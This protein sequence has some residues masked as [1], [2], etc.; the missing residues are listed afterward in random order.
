ML[1][2]FMM[3][4]LFIS[5]LLQSLLAKVFG[6]SSTLD[7]YTVGNSISFLFINWIA[8]GA[9][10]YVLVPVFTEYR[11]DGK[12]RIM[13]AANSFIAFLIFFS[14]FIT[15]VF[16]VIAPQIVSIL[17]RGFDTPTLTLAVN[18]AR[19][20]MPVF[21]I[22]V[23]CGI[24][25]GLLRAYE[26]YNITAIARCFE[27][28][29]IIG[30]I[31]VFGKTLG[32]YA[33]PVGMLSGALLSLAVH[34]HY[35]PRTG[36]RFRFKLIVREEKVRVMVSTF[37]LFGLISMSKHLVFLVDRLVASFLAP[38]SIA[39][40]HFASRFQILIVMIVPMAVS[41]P[42]F[43]RLNQHLYAQDKEKVISTIHHGL[44]LIAVMVFPLF[45]LFVLVRVPLIELWLQHGA[46]SSKDTQ[47]VAM[48]FLCLA[49][50]FLFESAA[51]IAAN[52]YF[53]LKDLKVLK[54]LILI[55]LIEVGLNII[56]DLILVR[57]YG[58]NGIALA[59]SIVKLP[60]TLIGWIYIGNYL[61]GLRLRNLIPYSLK[62]A[63]ASMCMIPVVLGM[64]IY[65]QGALEFTIPGRCLHLG[66]LFAFG[67]CTYIIF[68]MLFRVREI[69]KLSEM[70]RSKLL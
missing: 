37:F 47:S 2:F 3:G 44:R 1:A 28:L 29:P 70:L 40:Y 55:V 48:L 20:T 13:D 54:I 51:P 15:I 33:V 32:I 12:G 8:Y 7:A 49:P 38:G 24:L 67:G 23:I 31:L 26:I 36:L 6:A 19:M 52:I 10:S 61:G 27:L 16:E 9:I 43:T 42:F 5:F 65:L 21:P 14:L 39:L 69:T 68:G 62:V 22:M 17:G 66:I 50:S 46:F 58:L 56:L 11:L 41:I 63:A 4:T 64:D 57:F 30:A 34:L 59:T 53:S 35:A 60:T 25:S 45:T 18:L